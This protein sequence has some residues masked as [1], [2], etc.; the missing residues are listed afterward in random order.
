[1]NFLIL[2]SSNYSKKA[3][4][5]YSNKGNIFFFNDIDE[6]IF[7]TID[8]IICRLSIRLDSS[9]I[10]KFPK[11]KYIVSPTTAL[12][13]IDCEYAS[14][15]EI[16]IYSLRNITNSIRSITSTSELAI[17]LFFSLIRNIVDASNDVSLKNKWNRDHFR[18]RQIYENF[19]IGII[20]FGRIG[21]QIY[22]FLMPFNLNF[23]V[24]DKVVTDQMIHHN[25]PNQSV[26]NLIEKSDCIFLCAS[27]NNGDDPILDS[28]FFDKLKKSIYIVNTSRGEL[29]DEDALCEAIVNGK[30]FGFASDVLTN[31][32]S[33]NF[34]ENKKIM[35]LRESHKI[36]ITPHIG[37][38]TL[39]AMMETEYQIAENFIKYVK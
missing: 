21:E 11:L 34:L 32:L 30:V 12:N 38:C 22:R 28:N 9:F 27:Y 6:S 36:I 25:I 19:N 13:H 16:E 23:F 7:N 24:H 17:G 31:E 5:I 29:I 1:M 26:K 18:G 14:L 8:V 35:Q 15:K 39:E 33:K 4:E 2:E 3:L 20:G 10:D 37:G